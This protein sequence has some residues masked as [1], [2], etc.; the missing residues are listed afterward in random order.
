MNLT[1][2]SKVVL[3]LL[4][5]LSLITPALLQ[6]Q[7]VSSN[8]PRSIEGQL[9]EITPPSPTVANLMKFEEVPVNNYS[10]IPDISIPLYS[11]DTHSKDIN[12]DIALKYHPSSVA[13]LETASYT[14]LGWSLFAGGT[15][16]RTVKGAPDEGLYADGTGGENYRIGVLQD[17]IADAGDSYLVNRYEQVLGL[18]GPNPT[19]NDSLKDMIG[20][21]GWNVCQKGWMDTEYDLYQYNF[22]GYTG[23]FMIK[24]NPVTQQLEPI[25]L[26]NNNN[27]KIVFNYTQAPAQYG[28]SF[29]YDYTFDGFDL[30]D[31][32][33]YKYSF[34]AK[35]I[36][37]ESVS[38]SSFAFTGGSGS[39]S[40]STLNYISAYNLT[41]IYDNNDKIIAQF[42]Y[43]D[44]VEEVEMVN[45][46]QSSI[47][48]G[49]Y[50]A[51]ASAGF[52]ISGLL[53]R[54]ITQKT[55]TETT[56]KKLSLIEVTDKARINFYTGLGRED[57][58]LNKNTDEL[59]PKL[60]SIV[61]KNWY[62]ERIKQY[63]FTYDYLTIAAGQNS[64]SRL[65]LSMITEK[66]CRYGLNSEQGKELSHVMNY[67]FPYASSQVGLKRDYWGYFSQRLR[68][69]KRTDEKW[70]STHVLE[71]IIY[72]TG[73]SVVFDWGPNTY[74]Y[75]GDKEITDFTDDSE[76]FLFE[77]DIP[78]DGEVGLFPLDTQI[79]IHQIYFV[80]ESPVDGGEIFV[81]PEFSRFGQSL[82]TLGDNY[83][84]DGTART[85]TF[86]FKSD[87]KY[88]V[89]YASPDGY[90]PIKLRAYWETANINP[91]DSLW[92]TGGGLR[93]N[94]ISY[95]ADANQAN[96]PSKEKRF[97]YTKFDDPQR[98]SGSLVSPLPLYNYDQAKEAYVAASGSSGPGGTIIDPFHL[99]PL[100][101]FSSTIPP[102]ATSSRAFMVVYRNQTLLNNLKYIRT[103]GSDVGY[104]N[105]TVYETGNGKTE[106]TYTSPIDYPEIN[107]SV[108]PPFYFPLDKDYKRGLLQKE[109]QYSEDNSNFTQYKP[110]SE[111]IYEYQIINDSIPGYEGKILVG[112]QMPPSPSPMASAYASYDLFKE[113]LSY[114]PDWGSSYDLYA[115]HSL[116]Q[117]MEVHFGWPVL[118][119][120]TTNNY[121]YP[122]SN[123][124][125]Q[126]VSSF[127]EYKYN[128]NLKKLAEF[129][130]VTSKDE[131]LNTQYFYDYN[132]D[133]RNR[134]GVLRG[135]ESYRN[136]TLI[137]KKS[138]TFSNT[139]W[140]AGNIS[141]LPRTISI[142]KGNITPEPKIQFLRYD[143]YSNPVEAKQEDGKTVCYIWGYDSSYPIAIIE[144]MDYSTLVS[145]TSWIGYV[146]NAIGYSNLKPGQSQYSQKTT[147]MLQNLN[148]LRAALPSVSPVTVFA[149]KPLVGAIAKIDTRGN[150]TTYSYDGFGRLEE[151]R[152]KEFNESNADEV[153]NLISRNIYNFKPNSN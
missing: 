70:C 71:S 129:S 12:I 18:L 33:G 32:K 36:T 39:A 67:R 136:D 133:N 41:A 98:S 21:Y 152:E 27:M 128:F 130:T 103:Q 144:N 101:K 150:K 11:V 132:Y 134:V 3:S 55:R 131:I 74:S 120:K 149:Y 115:F 102:V 94:K 10:G 81:R 8:A 49:P 138:I 29:F 75:E 48:T 148:N 96:T 107:F 42:F 112:Y 151:I 122:A 79:D 63:K 61:V 78:A 127:E 38:N 7:T 50:P 46:T 51:I 6:A 135:T 77:M 106:Y 15:I 108:R 26:D 16:S 44:A 100:P 54:S 47:T 57:S 19:L 121:F 153:G 97:K 25:K 4:F 123:A 146:N 43:T 87:V 30:F 62:G 86:L 137:D 5:C 20:R 124:S 83:R 14:G 28:A 119:K 72:P 117:E 53:P 58:N 56:T 109:K 66:D 80:P 2:K 111:S 113:A 37:K 45:S 89:S 68:G 85:A 145:N 91:A 104:K 126:I 35:E 31:D 105:V 23:R 140:G 82:T 76:Q 125:A 34:Q 69:S 52:Q 139:A 110:V 1:L 118:K 116:G 88:Y 9:P 40:Y 73:G 65:A 22:M 13:V 59:A 64:L 95:Y 84:N 141:F 17:N 142:G 147:L 99:E 92:L 24:R 60:D 90:T 114:G 93:I 143:Q